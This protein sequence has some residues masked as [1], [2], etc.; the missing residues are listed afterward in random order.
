M[1]GRSPSSHFLDF[2]PRFVSLQTTGPSP[3]S[4]PHPPKGPLYN[5]PQVLPRLDLR[6]PF[7]SLW[8]S[9]CLS[10]LWRLHHLL[11][12]GYFM[13][14]SAI[15]GAPTFLSVFSFWFDIIFFKSRFTRI[16]IVKTFRSIHIYFFF[17]VVFHININYNMFRNERVSLRIHNM[18]YLFHGIFFFIK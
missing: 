2:H 3:D 7:S 1:V 11:G 13:N 12:I 17:A 4:Y 5:F 10:V 14:R 8:G 18:R 16:C 15:I 9:V 6:R